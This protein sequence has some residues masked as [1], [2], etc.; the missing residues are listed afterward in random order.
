MIS[1][2]SMSG[3]NFWLKLTIST[4][5]FIGER[6]V[7]ETQI[8]VEESSPSK[9]YSFASIMTYSGETTGPRTATQLA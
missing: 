3:H 5:I 6:V 7:V 4:L 1:S 2:A 8:F 9:E